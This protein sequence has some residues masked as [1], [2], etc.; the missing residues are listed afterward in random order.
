MQIE[1]DTVGKL[2]CH[3]YPYEYVDESKPCS[4]CAFFFGLQQ[5]TGETLQ[6]QKFD[7]RSTVEEFRQGLTIFGYGKGVDVLV[8][9]VRKRQ[10]PSYIFPK[11]YKCSEQSSVEGDQLLE[12]SVTTGSGEENPKRKRDVVVENTRQLEK[13]RHCIPLECSTVS[14]DA[15]FHNSGTPFAANSHSLV[16]VAENLALT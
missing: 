11:G 14:R 3:P 8:S 4:H 10:L 13:R 12:K 6:G 5:K 15:I 1:R 9:H 7:I 16:G 2:Q